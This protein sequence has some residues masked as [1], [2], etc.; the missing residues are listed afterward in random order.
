MRPFLEAG[1]AVFVDKILS[2][3]MRTTEELLGLA[4]RTGAPIAAWSQLRFASGLAKIA[5]LP[6]G[7]AALASFRMGL[8]ILPFYS[9]HLISAVLGAFG[10]GVKSLQKLACGNGVEVRAAYGDGTRIL[11]HLG[12]ESPPSM[13]M[14]YFAKTGCRLA[15]AGDSYAMFKAA[16][17]TLEKM[18]T[19]W[20]SPV[21]SEEISEAARIVAFIVGARVGEMKEF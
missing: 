8:D 12:P 9:I 14:C 16:A 1:K 6:R 13:N 11:M 7:G 18:M 20:K 17:A 5:K 4:R 2:L 15:D 19:E 21:P 3:D 10:V